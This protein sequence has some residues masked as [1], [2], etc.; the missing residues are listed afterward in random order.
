MLEG[1]ARNVFLVE[2]IWHGEVRM[3]EATLRLTN[4]VIDLGGG[5]ARHFILDRLQSA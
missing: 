4:E 1:D 2:E 3:L 5:N